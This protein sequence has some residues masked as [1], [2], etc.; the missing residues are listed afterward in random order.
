MINTSDTNNT[1]IIINEKGELLSIDEN[2]KDTFDL[3]L[4][5]HVPK[6]EVTSL[7]EK[8]M[9]SDINR[10]QKWLDVLNGVEIKNI[11]T[12]FNWLKYLDTLKNNLN[13]IV[14]D[15]NKINF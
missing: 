8:H 13:S 3:K 15:Y 4:F 7:L 9:N 11:L 10:Y 1:N 6:K 12:E 14:S 2:P 5:S